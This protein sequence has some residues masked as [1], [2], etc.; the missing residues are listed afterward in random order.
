MRAGLLRRRRLGRPPPDDSGAPLCADVREKDTE[1]F[2]KGWP[3]TMNG[4]FSQYLEE[5]ARQ[6]PPEAGKLI[7]GDLNLTLLD[8]YTD[9]IPAQEAARR[10]RRSAGW[11]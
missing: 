5:V 1:Q 7:E 2:D 4:G 3:I 11:T 8:W 6:L 9:G 10:I